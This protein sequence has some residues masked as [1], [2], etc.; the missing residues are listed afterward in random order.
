MKIG[1]TISWD[2][3]TGIKS[4]VIERATRKGYLARLTNGKC[5]IVGIRSIRRK[6]N[7]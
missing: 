7:G 2:T 3:V 5:V 6:D 4:G 1:E